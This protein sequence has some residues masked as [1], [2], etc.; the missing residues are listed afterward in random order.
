MESVLKSLPLGKAV[1]PDGINNRILRELAHELSNPLCSLINQSLRI[2]IFPDSW[3]DAHVCPIFKAGDSASVSNYRHISL[4]SCLEKVSERAVFKHL[5]NHFY[6]NNIL[7][8]LQSGFIPGDSTTNQLT[9]LCNTFCQALDSGKEVRVVFCDVSKA[10][11]RVWHTGLLCKL[12]AAGVSGSLLPWLGS[13]RSN[14]RQRVTLPGTQ[15]NWNYIDAGVPQGSILGPLLFLLY[16]NDIVK[17]SKSNIRLFADDTSLFS[18]VE[19]P[20]SAAEILNSDLE[21]ITKWAKD[22]LVTFNPI[23]TEAMLL[24]RKLLQSANH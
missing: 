12:K 9:F 20:L 21:K 3:K 24:S 14:R 23:K 19:N 18:V 5:Y 1:G 6:D 10:F 8:P 16:I 22:W 11:D 4:F 2:G 17:D 13:Y 7:R 15:S